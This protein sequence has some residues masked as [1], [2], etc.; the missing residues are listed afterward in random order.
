MF[1]SDGLEEEE[2]EEEEEEKTGDRQLG[3]RQ[4]RK[5]SVKKKEEI[6]E[7]K[8]VGSFSPLFLSLSLSLSLP[9]VVLELTRHPVGPYRQE[10]VLCR[11]HGGVLRHNHVLV[12]VVCDQNTHDDLGCST[13]RIQCGSGGD[14]EGRARRRVA[15][16]GTRSLSRFP[17]RSDGFP[18]SKAR[19]S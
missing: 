19:L 5:E 2:E 3:E 18:T 6:G 14:H 16:G 11:G 1:F 10:E 8:R 17:N 13:G 4:R 15:R 9:H 7:A 12:S